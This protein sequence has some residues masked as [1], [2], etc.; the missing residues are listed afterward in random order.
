MVLC[1]NLVIAQG[2]MI[3]EI[4][5]PQ[6][7]SDAGRYVEIY[8]PSTDDIDLSTGYALQRWTNGNA[9]PQS[10]VALTGTIAAGGFYVVC[11]DAAEF[12]VTYGMEASQD[13]GGGGPADSNGDDNIALLGPDGSIID[14]FGVAGEDGTGTGHEFE[15]GRA[16]RACGAVASATWIEADWNIDND[17]G[18]GDG[19]QYAPE[20]FD[21]FAWVCAVAVADVYGCTDSTACNY[22]S[23]ANTDDD[24][25][26][27]PNTNADCNGDCL[28]GFVLVQG[29]GN[30][31]G[32]GNGNGSGQCISILEGCTDELA[33]NYNSDA[34][35][36]DDTCEYPNTN[37]L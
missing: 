8:N 31:S 10:A 9:D 36:D 22:N 13:I 17:S 28:D 11:N 7:S 24:S 33:C 30:G 23:D 37:R 3:T 26:E 34:N 27:Y 18:G 15:D 32:T 16:E 25:C 5:D 4:T 19:N 29:G 14:M 35:T 12:L 1:S 20:G 21:P 6:N 2:L